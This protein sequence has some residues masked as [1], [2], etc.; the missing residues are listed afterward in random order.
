MRANKIIELVLKEI[1]EQF[2]RKY[3]IVFL[4]MISI[5][6]VGV[7]LTHI[8]DLKSSYDEIREDI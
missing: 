6:S 4:I 1:K 2:K 8:I 7:G 3:I 5:I